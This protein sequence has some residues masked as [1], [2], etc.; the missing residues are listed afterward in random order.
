MLVELFGG[1]EARPV[2]MRDGVVLHAP[3]QLYL[4]RSTRLA[5]RAQRRALRALYATC[6]IPECE[7]RFDRCKIHHVHWWRHG[8]RTDIDNLLPLCVQHH[9]KVHSQGWVITLGPGRVLT[10]RLPDGTVHNTGPPGRRA[11]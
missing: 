6:A 10:L 2:I 8:G 9:S 7:T 1:A 3:G 4:G 11:A 5:N